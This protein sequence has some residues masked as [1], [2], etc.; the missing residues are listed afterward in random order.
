MRDVRGT[1]GRLKAVRQLAANNLAI[2]LVTSGDYEGARRLLEGPDR[3]L[4]GPMPV[5]RSLNLGTI[6][7]LEGDDVGD[8]RMFRSVIATSPDDP[9]ALHGLAVIAGSA[10]AWTGDPPLE[11]ALNAAP[12]Q[13]PRHRVPEGDASEVSPRPSEAMTKVGLPASG[14]LDTTLTPVS[15]GHHPGAEGRVRQGHRAAH[16]R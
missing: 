16:P 8:E 2:V 9:V 14:M 10:R 6:A 11:A 12:R 15:L 1:D 4:A 5:L 7:L 3:Q 13:A